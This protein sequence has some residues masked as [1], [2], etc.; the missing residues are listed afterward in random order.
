[1]EEVIAFLV[2]N[3]IVPLGNFVGFA[4]T[5][6]IAF[7]L[8]AVLW[9]GFAWAL[10]ASQGNLHAA[11]QWSRELPLIAQGL[12]WLFFLPVMAALWIWETTWPLVFR[13]IA[14]AGLAGWSLM[15]F[16]PKWLTAARP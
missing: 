7:V 14:I 12:V 5:S 13:L 8:F 16:L 10:V 11:W 1:M 15:M 2:D 9:A 4:A 6:G 3:T